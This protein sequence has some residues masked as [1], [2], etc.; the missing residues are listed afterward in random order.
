M[1]LDEMREGQTGRI[2]RIRGEARLRRRILEMGLTKGSEIYIEKY[3]PLK[4]PLE[5]VVRGCHV[6]LRVREAAEIDVEAV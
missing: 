3:A 4:D 1:R 6:S 5:L 2:L